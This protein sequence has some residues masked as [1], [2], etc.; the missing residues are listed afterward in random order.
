MLL[1]AAASLPKLASPAGAADLS[2]G[3]SSTL[4]SAAAVARTNTSL[5]DGRISTVE[6]VLELVSD[7]SDVLLTETS[8]DIRSFTSAPG[9]CAECASFAPSTSLAENRRL[10][11]SSLSNSSSR[12]DAS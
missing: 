12:S 6:R 8:S 4:A 7:T 10:L 2:N 11:G 5:I 1:C 9:M 3:T